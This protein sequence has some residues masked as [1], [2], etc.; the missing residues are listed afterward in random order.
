MGES[1]HLPAILPRCHLCLH[2]S[3]GVD[4]DSRYVVSVLPAQLAV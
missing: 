3:E 1:F 2:L 4:P